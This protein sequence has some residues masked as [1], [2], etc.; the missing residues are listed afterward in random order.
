MKHYL[1]AWY[2]LFVNVTVNCGI[3][4]DKIKSALWR[5][6]KL[7]LPSSIKYAAIICGTKNIYFNEASRIVNELLCVTSTLLSKSINVKVLI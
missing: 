6:V 1:H 4:G 5:A 3:P 2:K 7:K